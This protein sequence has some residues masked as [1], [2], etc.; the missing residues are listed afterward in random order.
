MFARWLGEPMK[1]VSMRVV[2]DESLK[3]L[4]P[5]FSPATLKQ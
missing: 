4:R 3:V 2:A 1:A 5:M